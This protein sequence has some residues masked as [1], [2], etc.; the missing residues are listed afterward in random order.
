M[1]CVLSPPLSR[2]FADD[3]EETCVGISITVS[4]DVAATRIP[5]GIGCAAEENGGI[6]KLSRIGPSTG[7]S[8]SEAVPTAALASSWAPPALLDASVANRSNEF[9]VRT[10]RTGKRKAARPLN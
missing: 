8:T 5:L 7:R 2:D 9:V 10:D 6:A 1:A 4:D 3:G